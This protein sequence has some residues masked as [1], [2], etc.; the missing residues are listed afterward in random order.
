MPEALVRLSVRMLVP[1]LRVGTHVWTL[2]IG[3]I[4]FRHPPTRR[5][6]SG[7]AFPRGAWEQDSLGSC[8]TKRAV[9][10]LQQIHESISPV[11]V[12]ESETPTFRSCAETRS[13]RSAA[14]Q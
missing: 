12:G 2:C 1:T 14:P 3:G 7:V 8:A 10:S 4:R 6:A 13:A 5:R 11:D 9:M